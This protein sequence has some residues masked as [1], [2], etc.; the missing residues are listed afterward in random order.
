[1]SNCALCVVCDC[2]LCGNQWV[3]DKEMHGH[4]LLMFKKVR[5]KGFD[6]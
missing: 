5:S 2:F 1:M 6:S 3:C 4:D